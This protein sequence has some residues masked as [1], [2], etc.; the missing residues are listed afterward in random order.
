M[1]SGDAVRVLNL[2]ARIG[3][4]IVA[5]LLAWAP[6]T[7]GAGVPDDGRFG[8]IE[9]NDGIIGNQDRHYT[10]GFLF[11]RLYPE[12]KIDGFLDRS[13]DLLGTLLPMYRPAND[14]ERHVEWLALG[15]SEFTPT[16]TKIENIIPDD[17]PYAAWLYTGV[18][19]LQENRGNQ[20]NDIEL[21]GGVVGSW[22]LGRQIQDGFHAA[23]GFGQAEGWGHQLANRAAVQFSY[24][25]K[26][27]LGFRF[28]ASRWG[29][30]AVPEAGF[31]VGTVFRYAQGSLLLRAGNGL[32][33]NY[34]PERIQPALSGSGFMS[35]A[36]APSGGHFYVFGGAQLRHMWYDTFLDRS[37][38]V[39]PEGLDTQ[40]SVIDYVFG[41]SIFAGS[42]LR[43]DLS[44]TRRTREFTTQQG[45]D[46]F[47]SVAMSLRF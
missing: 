33:V 44:V 4:V 34:G 13:Y 19:L 40:R 29:A 30:D 42:Y 10:Q 26:R 8:F 3:L 25:F 21:T 46:I 24:D 1:Q 36:R 47:S 6:M 18:S 37:G 9:E 20:L 16:D 31:S 38:E 11:T 5:T 7:L 43:F 17:R 41:T 45:D 12:P 14:S 27:K 32:D 39:L 28:G 23:A 22:A 35:D 15:Q 2:P